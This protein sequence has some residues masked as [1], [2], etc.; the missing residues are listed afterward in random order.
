MTVAV[1]FHLLRTSEPYP[2]VALSNRI[3]EISILIKDALSQCDYYSVGTPEEKVGKYNR[4]TPKEANQRL[5]I[6]RET[7]RDERMKNH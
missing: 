2:L 1:W 3:Q 5:V 4:Q 6:T 7:I